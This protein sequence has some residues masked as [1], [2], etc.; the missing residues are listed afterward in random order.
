MGFPGGSVVKSPSTSAG[1]SGGSPGQED[2][3][4]KKMAPHS[5]ILAWETPWTEEPQ[6]LQSKELQ[7]SQ[8]QLRE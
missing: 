8:T 1:I 2:P 4:E 7:K 6:G 3:L 5:G